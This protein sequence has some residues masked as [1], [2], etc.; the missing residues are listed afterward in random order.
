MS[1]TGPKPVKSETLSRKTIGK[2]GKKQKKEKKPAKVD[3][4]VEERREARRLERKN[5][6]G[7]R[8]QKKEEKMAKRA[9]KEVANVAK[10]EAVKAEK[11]RLELLKGEEDPRAQPSL[12]DIHS[13]KP[14]SA[15]PPDKRGLL[16]PGSTVAL[17]LRTTHALR[18]LR[19]RLSEKCAEYD[20]ARKVKPLTFDRWRFA[21]RW[22]EQGAARKL[23]GHPVL[24]A[25]SAASKGGTKPLIKPSQSAL[26]N[27]LFEQGM[28]LSSSSAVAADLI[29]QSNDIA[30]KVI[31]NPSHHSGNNPKP[32]QPHIRRHAYPAS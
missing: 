22:D 11:A 29:Q 4:E 9:A 23:V 19:A 15:P 27:D 3:P 20:M 7:N 16:P 12:W 24:P 30:L 21:A 13:A 32:S 10:E 6:R 25:S 8:E 2:D 14:K 18:K 5:G 28:L 17:E 26:Q 31:N 1:K